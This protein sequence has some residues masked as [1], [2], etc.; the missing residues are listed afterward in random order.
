LPLTTLNFGAAWNRCSAIWKNP[1]A[2]KG[3]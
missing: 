2:R 3:G 1:I